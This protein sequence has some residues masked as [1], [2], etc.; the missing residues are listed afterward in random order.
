MVDGLKQDIANAKGKMALLETGDWGAASDARVA[1]K[2]RE[3]RPGA[4]FFIG[5]IGGRVQS[6]D[7]RG[8]VAS[9]RPCGAAQVLQ[10]QGSMAI[11]PIFSVLSP[12]G[13]LVESELRA[14]LDE[15]I[16]LS[17]QE[18]RASVTYLAERGPCNQ[19]GRWWNGLGRC[20]CRCG[21]DG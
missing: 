18:L 14:K 19:Y 2:R 5:R 13:R 16:S 15:D 20:R 9:T 17:W 11:G 1:M 21:P 4:A 12:L 7:I 10:C 3:V 8:P 6:G